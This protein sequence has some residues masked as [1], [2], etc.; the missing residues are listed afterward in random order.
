MGFPIRLNRVLLRTLVAFPL[1]LAVLSAKVLLNPSQITQSSR[2]IVVDTR[3]FRADI[4]S[5]LDLFARSLP[6][7]PRQI[8]T[9]PV[10]L[11]ILIPLKPFAANFAD[12]SVRGHKGLGRQSNHLSIWICNNKTQ[13]SQK[14]P[15]NPK[16]TKQVKGCGTE[17]IWG[18]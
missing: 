5:L 18:F 16:L 7:L 1:L 9:S 3:S 12:E 14:Q 2:R 10:K 17:S 4:D 13:E 8:M 6:Q 11:Q 15:R